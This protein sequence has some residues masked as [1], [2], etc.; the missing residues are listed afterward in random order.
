MVLNNL[1]KS[2]FECELRPL[3]R[4][5]FFKAYR[6]KKLK[7]IIQGASGAFGNCRHARRK[8]SS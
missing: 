1:G 8:P 2:A 3:E 6:E 5:A 7:N 4:A